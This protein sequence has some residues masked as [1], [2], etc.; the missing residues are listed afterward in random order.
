MCR[1]HAITPADMFFWLEGPKM[2]FTLKLARYISPRVPCFEALFWSR[3]GLQGLPKA[4]KGS[5]NVW[6][7]SNN[8][9]GHDLLEQR[10]PKWLANMFFDLCR[11]G[12]TKMHDVFKSLLP[13]YF[14]KDIY[15]KWSQFEFQ[16]IWSNFHYTPRRSKFLLTIIVLAKFRLKMIFEFFLIKVSQKL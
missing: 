4:N 15:V 7:T 2:S 11:L 8:T 1:Q 3:Q 10:G 5:H 13:R 14:L 6:G 12:W 16:T 9:D